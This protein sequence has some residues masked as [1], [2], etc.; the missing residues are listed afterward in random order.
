MENH[1]PQ[2]AP[3]PVTKDGV[4]YF[5][6]RNP[7][8]VFALKAGGRGDVAGSHLVWSADDVDTGL[9]SPVL[10][11]GRL[12]C[13]STRGVLACL[14]AATGEVLYRERASQGSAEFYASPLAADGKIYCV[15]RRDG[16][17]VFAA[18]D[19]FQPLGEIRF[20][21]DDSLFNASP[22]AHGGQLLIRSRKFLYCIGG[23]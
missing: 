8:R 3:S 9:T 19:E 17:F 18:G 14:D 6:D 22:I 23:L 16:A 4:I 5:V 12:Y 20:E 13:L 15:S 21:G 2:S 7:A 1:L 10:Y 11:E